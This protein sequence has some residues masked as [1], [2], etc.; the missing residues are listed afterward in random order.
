MPRPPRIEFAGAN[1]HIVTHSSM[2]GYARRSKRV[3]WVQYKLQL[4][5]R[6][7]GSKD[8]LRRMIALAESGDRHRHEST[9]RRVHAVTVTAVLEA[10]ASHHGVDR[11]Q[12]AVFRSAAP[13]RDMAAWLDRGHAPETRS[14]L[15]AYRHR[16]RLQPGSPCRAAVQAIRQLA[17][18]GQ[19]NRGDAPP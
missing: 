12:Y 14:G 19:R 13:G 6:V 10:T 17:N 7:S 4:G 2:P 5:E 1:Y 3:D 9:I 11:L 18:E 8:F 15:W 16:Q